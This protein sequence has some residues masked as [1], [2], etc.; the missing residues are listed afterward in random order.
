MK[1]GCCVHV[2]ACQPEGGHWNQSVCESHWVW[3]KS[4]RTQLVTHRLAASGLQPG[5]LLEQWHLE[6]LCDLRSWGYGSRVFV[7]EMG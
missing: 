3:E 6:W 7:H 2:K 1:P 5:D 4:G